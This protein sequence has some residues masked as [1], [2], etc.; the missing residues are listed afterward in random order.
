MPYPISSFPPIIV[1]T[2]KKIQC[3]SI[4][5]YIYQIKSNNKKGSDSNIFFIVSDSDTIISDSDKQ[6]QILILYYIS[7]SDTVTQ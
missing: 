5:R 2:V 6:N 1:S 3:H 7:D 4:T